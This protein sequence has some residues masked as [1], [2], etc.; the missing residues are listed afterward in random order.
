MFGLLDSS[1]VTVALSLITTWSEQQYFDL[2][3]ALASQFQMVGISSSDE[4]MD[5]FAERHEQ[6]EAVLMQQLVEFE[7]AALNRGDI[8]YTF[9][10]R[11]AFE[12]A[13]PKAKN[14]TVFMMKAAD[15][16]RAAEYS[17]NED[18]TGDVIS[19]IRFTLPNNVRRL[20]TEKMQRDVGDF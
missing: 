10:E 8:V 13:G 7:A 4:Y 15:D 19:I 18:D 14:Y 2:L 1:L 6:P 11:T 12:S 5:I 20:V 9:V 3:T 17:I 16:F